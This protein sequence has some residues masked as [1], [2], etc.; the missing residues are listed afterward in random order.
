MSKGI[1]IY[2][3]H[4]T[5]FEP[6]FS[7]LDRR[8]LEYEKIDAATHSYDPEASPVCDLL[9][10]RMS[11]SAY[12]RGNASAI[13]YTRGFLATIERAGVRVINGYEAYQIE[14]SKALQLSLFR[15]LG[16]KAPKTRVINSIRELGAIEGLDFPLIVKPNIGG[17]GAG[18]DR[19]KSAARSQGLYRRDRIDGVMELIPVRR[20]CQAMLTCQ[21]LPSQR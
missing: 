9:F 5:W 3:E 18:I 19:Q 8:G 13:F 2:F 10:N 11:A 16:L 17:R 6:L 21:F 14:I 15:S 12:L 4:P 7:A 20:S 1:G